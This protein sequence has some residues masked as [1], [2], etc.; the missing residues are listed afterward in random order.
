MSTYKRIFLLLGSNCL[1]FQY[2]YSSA[3]RV[4]QLVRHPK[5]PRITIITSV[6]K[7]DKFIKGFLED[8][9]EQTVFDQCELLL[10]NANSPGNEEAV[11]KPYLARYP[12]ITYIQLDEDPGIYS[13]WNLGIQLARSEYITNANTDDR[14]ASNCYELHAKALDKHPEVDLVYSDHVITSKPNE[15]LSS[16]RA[17]KN[18]NFA[19]FKASEMHRC[20]PG[21]NPMWRKSVHAK[22]GYFNADFISAGDW[23]MWCRAV[24]GGSIFKKVHAVTG[25]YYR[26][27]DGLSSSPL[28]RVMAEKERVLIRLLYG[29]LFEHTRLA[30]QVLAKQDEQIKKRATKERRIKTH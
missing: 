4:D 1:F 18:S 17:T 19:R 10:I 5:S 7:S 14:L 22:H 13:V 12:N 15:T 28:F 26:N 9:I 25:L 3:Q 21:M 20:L 24:E 8:I 30:D 2:A 16:T 6:Y 11:I 29:S 27:P 23:E